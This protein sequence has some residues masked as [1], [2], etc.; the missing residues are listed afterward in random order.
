VASL[1][2]LS[3]RSSIEGRPGAFAHCILI[4]NLNVFGGS[5]DLCSGD[6]YARLGAVF[7]PAIQPAR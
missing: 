4:C 6:S 1:S 2:D 3:Q 7:V 5:I